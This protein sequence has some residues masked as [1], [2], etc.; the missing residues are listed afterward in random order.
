MSQGRFEV[1]IIRPADTHLSSVRTLWRRDRGTLGFFPDGALLEHSRKGWLLGAVVSSGELA[2]Y[3]LYRVTRA[4]VV[5]VH[6]CVAEKFRGRGVAR[7][8]VDALR[9]STQDCSGMRASCRADY[10]AN[11]MWPVLNFTAIAERPAREEGRTLKTWWLDYGNPDLL[12]PVGGHTPVAVLD[13]NVFF[14]LLEGNGE[15]AEESQGLLAEWFQDVVQLAVAPE[16]Y[17]EIDRRKKSNERYRARRYAGRFHRVRPR[18]AEST[19]WSERLKTILRSTKS[20]S[21]V[22]DRRQLAGAIA[23]GARFFITRDGDVLDRAAKVLEESG[24]Q[25]LRP[26]ELISLG[27]E[28]INSV[29]YQPARLAGVRIHLGRARGAEVDGLAQRFLANDSGER[30]TALLKILR[31][32]VAVPEESKL[33]T[34]TDGEDKAVGLVM[35]RDVGVDTLSVDLLRVRGGRIETTLARH[36]AWHVVRESVLRGKSRLEVRDRHLSTVVKEALSRLC[37]RSEAGIFAKQNARGLLTME[38]MEELVGSESRHLAGTG[39]PDAGEASGMDLTALGRRQLFLESAL[40]PA[41]ASDGVLHTYVV[42]IRPNWAMQLFDERSSAA[43]LFG[44]EPHLI[45]QTENVYYRAPHPPL[46]GSPARV[47]WYVSNVNGLARS[48]QIL[49]CS[50]VSG[51]TVGP[52]KDV[53]RRFQRLGAFEWADVLRMAHAD[54]M[55]EILAFTFGYTELFSSPVGWATLR[56]LLEDHGVRGVTLQG[57]IRIT[58]ALFRDI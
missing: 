7:T 54:P 47:L 49:A 23:G 1:R 20:K 25:I 28:E 40:W 19:A 16:L 12:S 46:P 30:K 3:L 42:P 29:N 21:D 10:R 52:A 13:A 35:V 55:R 27:D 58:D 50:L 36:L 11:D 34:V 38:A 44:A 45:L 24:I 48:K 26:S 5:I 2:G 43:D 51:M 4:A 18:P 17:N 6:L 14:D 31:T 57:P 41:K 53:F 56:K 8:L 15:G 9:L 32:A 37:F 33:W 39:R 22:S